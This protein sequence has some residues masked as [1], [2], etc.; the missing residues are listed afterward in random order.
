MASLRIE[1]GRR[2]SGQV[3]VEGNKNSALPLL[4][5]CLLTE[6]E[7]VLENVPRIR[8]VEVLIELMRG[9][10]ADGRRRRHA[11][12]SRSGARRSRLTGPTRSWSASCAARCSCSDRCSRGRGSRQAGAAWRRLSRA[13]DHRYASAGARVRWELWRSTSPVTLSTRRTG[14]AARRCISTKLPSPGRRRRFLP[15]L[16]P[17][18]A[19]RSAMPPW[20][21]TSSS[22]V[23]F[24]RA[25]GVSIEGEGTTTIRVEAP[26]RCRGARHTLAGDYIEAGSWGVV[27]AITGGDIR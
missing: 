17:A 15:P 20:N 2:L 26:K 3:S 27:A 10:G 9:F 16:W 13:P 1:G 21:L 25:M 19:P 18:A 5:A 4:A 8:D 23:C 14:S 7:C 22:C 6:E 24:L 11:R 12:R